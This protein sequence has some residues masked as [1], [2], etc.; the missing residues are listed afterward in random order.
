MELQPKMRKKRGV[1]ITGY[2]LIFLHACWGNPEGHFLH[3]TYRCL[4]IMFP[5]FLKSW[6]AL[7]VYKLLYYPLPNSTAVP[8]SYLNGNTFLT[9]VRENW[10]QMLRKNNLRFVL[11][12]WTFTVYLLC[13]LKNSL[14][15]A[16]EQCRLGSDMMLSIIV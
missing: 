4:R 2:T 13:S 12:N 3:L 9:Q 5:T 7:K 14:L 6:W 8:L 10:K 16:L 1:T 15:I 11:L